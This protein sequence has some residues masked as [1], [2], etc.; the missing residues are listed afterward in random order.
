M[1]VQTNYTTVQQIFEL[2][3]SLSPVDRRVLI[4]RLNRQIVD[5]LQEKAT[6]D[7]A[8]ALY[9]AD[10]CSLGRAA[11]L[12]DVSRWEFMDVLKKRNIPLTVET[13][14]TTAEMDALEKELEREGLLCS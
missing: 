10:K 5:S 4:E 11:E 8:I 7:D 13:D 14:F 6:V 2:A 1:N 3:Q 9:L 12:A